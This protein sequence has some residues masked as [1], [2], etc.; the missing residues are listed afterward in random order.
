MTSYDDFTI[1]LCWKA[2]PN[3][4]SVANINN[5]PIV[6][7]EVFFLVHIPKQLFDVPQPAISNNSEKLF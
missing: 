7:P 2:F 3:I 1:F 4:N 6:Q 5:L